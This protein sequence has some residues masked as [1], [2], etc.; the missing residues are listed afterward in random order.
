MNSGN[1]GFAYLYFQGQRCERVDW[2][3][4]YYLLEEHSLYVRGCMV[5]IKEKM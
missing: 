1:L 4:C 2:A 5:A 3:Q